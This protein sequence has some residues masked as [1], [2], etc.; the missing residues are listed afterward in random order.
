MGYTK[1]K[2]YQ[3]FDIPQSIKSQK[4]LLRIVDFYL[5]NCPVPG[6]SCRG[7][8]FDEYGFSGSKSFGTLKN[9]MLNAATPSLKKNYYPCQKDEL[10]KHYSEVESVV[11]PDEYCVFLM[12]EDRTVMASLFSAIRNAFAHGSY[13]VKTYN[14]VKIYFFVNFNHYKK[15]QLVLQEKTLL[16]WINIIQSGYQ[17]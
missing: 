12:S 13:N 4:N 5:F 16:A 6:K 7:K 1:K 15:A 3:S 10:E 14:G 9:Q 17:L 8:K 11:P 2:Y